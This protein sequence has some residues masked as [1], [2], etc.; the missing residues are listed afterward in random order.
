MN[1]NECEE[2][3]SLF[4]DGELDSELSRSVQEHL[5]ICVNC[6]LLCEDFAAILNECR[7][8]PSR[9][10]PPV[11][12]VP[13]NS[14]ALWCRI[15]NIIENETRPNSA[16]PQTPEPPPSR[17]FTFGQL[18]SAVVGIAMISSLLTVIGIRN[19][20][21]SGDDRTARGAA[22]Q[23]A[24]EK[25]MVRVGLIES[26][27]DL[28]I[29]RFRE[30]QDAIEYWN[31]RVQERRA[32]WDERMRQAFDRNLREIEQAVTEYTMLL[33]TNPQDDL[34]GEMLNTA[35]DEKMNLLRAF[36]EL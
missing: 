21:G 34:S 27:Q 1:C 25:A 12:T 28:R 10:L 36:A 30:Q 9:D 16:G 6:T 2:N 31:R 23:S 26:P 35:M 13:P 14:K 33:E 15:N 20:Y 29:R 19:Y 3:L 17:G 7:G 8:V 32:L 11:E 5:T 24:F 18:L 4:L 22:A